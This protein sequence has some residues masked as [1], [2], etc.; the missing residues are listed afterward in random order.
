M[1]KMSIYKTTKQSKIYEK[2][3]KQEKK[4]LITILDTSIDE[5]LTIVILY[6]A[7]K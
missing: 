5:Y 4:G 2:M 1:N 6:E 7:C 3:L